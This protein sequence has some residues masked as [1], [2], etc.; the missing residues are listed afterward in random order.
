MSIGGKKTKEKSTNV[1]TPTNP[2]WATSLVQ[3]QAGRI[4]QMGAVDPYSLVPGASGLQQQSFAGAQALGGPSFVGQAFQFG[5]SAGKGGEDFTGPQVNGGPGD[6]YTPPSGGTGSMDNFD[7]ASMM[8]FGAGAGGPN[9]ATAQGYTPTSAGQ[10]QGY[11]AAL[12]SAGS[13]SSRGFDAAELQKRL[14]PYLTEVR[15]TALADFDVGAGRQQAAARLQASKN[16]GDWNSNNAIKDA[17]LSGEFTRG[18]GSLSAGISDQGFGRASDMLSRD[19]DRDAQTSIANAQ[20]Q[21]QVALANA[22]SKNGASQFGA[23]ANNQFALFNAGQGTDAARYGADAFNDNSRFNA[24][25]ADT[26]LARDLQAAGLLGTLGSAQGADDRANVAMQGDLGAQQ[27][28]IERQRLAA[29]YD[30]LALQNQLTGGLPLNLFNGSSSVGTG[31]SSSLGF[32]A[33][34]MKLIQAGAS[35]A[36][37]ISDVRMK[38]G[39]TP[40]GQGPTGDNLY[41]FGYKGDPSGERYV[42]PMAQEVAQTNPGAVSQGPGGLMEV[43]YNALGLPSPSQQSMGRSFAATQDPFAY[44]PV[45]GAPDL[46]GLMGQTRDQSAAQIR[47][48]RAAASPNRRPSR[49]LFGGRMVG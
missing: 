1:T 38:E 10:A 16:G 12:A 27:R 22:A 8:A 35:A 37:G 5:N 18:R 25:Q 21:T 19:N 28:E 3:D 2:E 43:D 42:G 30:Q 20:M 6:G 15:D 31:S 24:G 44:D 39:I 23:G 9:L 34:V 29:P 41:E 47:S 46:S 11:E 17:I 40:I 48:A 33:D 45:P 26:A 7:L 13:A 49:G 36:S 32:S 4:Q 14:S